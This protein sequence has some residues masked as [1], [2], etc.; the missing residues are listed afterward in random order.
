MARQKSFLHALAQDQRE[1]E[2]QRIAQWREQNQQ[3]AAFQR[4]QEAYFRAQEQTQRSQALEQ[5]RL[6]KEQLRLYGESRVAEVAWENTQLA[7]TLTHLEGILAA[8]FPVD[9]FFDLTRLKVQPSIP[10]FLP[11]PLATP[12]PTP[13]WPPYAPPAPSGVKRFLPGVQ[14]GYNQALAAAQARYDADVTAARHADA[15]RQAQ[16]AAAQAAYDQEVATLQAQTAAQ[17]AEI[18]SFQLDLSAGVPAALR[19]YF[20][21]VLETSA[22]PADFPHHASLAYIP[23]SQQLVIEYEL[24][25]LS[26]VPEVSSYKYVK[27]QDA[28]STTARPLPQRKALYQSVLAQVAIRTIH[29]I[30]ESDRSAQVANVVFNGYVEPIHPGTGHRTRTYL[31][32]LRTT[33][34][35]F[36]ALNLQGVEPLACLKELGAVVSKSPAE[37]APVRPVLD[38]NMVDPRFIEETDVLAELDQRPNL[39]ALTPSEFEALIAN[40][41]GKMGLETRLTQASRDGGVDCIAYDPRP[42]LGGKVVIQAK[43][44][45]DTVGVSAV[46]DLYGTVHN[47]GAAKGIL[48]TTSGYGAA[49]F[50]FA[51]NKPLELLSGGNL[52]YLLAEHAG[53]QAKI[54]PIDNPTL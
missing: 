25:S 3:A 23:E 7:A 19:D 27:S 10:P 49:A 35:A 13:E 8:T 47:E 51:K 44:Y 54:E 2:R 48:V 30:F 1:A 42:V 45:K 26:V 50:E 53:I 20:T 9:D 24:P 40:L 12:I 33:R 38:F 18:D 6:Y 17:H 29:E 34:P 32:S 52:L 5:A 11:G 31:L 4:A 36:L 37:L 28:I 21:L 22:Y 46:R 14:T 16:L 15:Q 43:R 41:F 39:L